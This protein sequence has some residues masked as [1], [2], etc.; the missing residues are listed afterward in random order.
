MIYVSG[1]AKLI[2]TVSYS[3]YAVNQKTL[4]IMN[5]V[6]MCIYHVCVCVC[7]C[8]CVS[9]IISFNAGENTDPLGTLRPKKHYG[10]FLEFFFCHN[11]LL[12]PLF[13]LFFQ[14]A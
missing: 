5:D 8:V 11:S 14:P 4:D 3:S 1:K 10:E 6:H 2:N 9:H 7:V 13:T 12:S